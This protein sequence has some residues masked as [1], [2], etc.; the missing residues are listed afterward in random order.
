[1]ILRDVSD[2]QGRSTTDGRVGR[3]FSLERRIEALV[4][5]IGITGSECAEYQERTGP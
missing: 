5:L 2:G 3:S 1:M 4:G